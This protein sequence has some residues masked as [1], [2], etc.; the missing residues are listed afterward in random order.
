MKI[1]EIK[2]FGDPVL[3]VKANPVTQFDKKLAEQLDGM[4]K[5]LNAAENGA[6][7]AANQVGLLKRMIVIDYCGERFEL[8]NPVIVKKV[9][10]LFGYEGCLSL[11]GYTGKVERAEQVWIE[12]QDRNGKKKESGRSGD[13]AVC[14]QHETDHLDGILFTDRMMEPYIVNNDME[15]KIPLETIRMLTGVRTG[16]L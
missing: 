14:F 5:T 2:H 15:E 6:A 10:S 4:W 12:Y 8:I 1:F 11:P 7:L 13:L 9:G 3:R 16:D